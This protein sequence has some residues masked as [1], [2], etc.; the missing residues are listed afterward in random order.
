MTYSNTQQVYGSGHII[1]FLN[2]PFNSFSASSSGSIATI[3]SPASVSI[4][5]FGEG[6]QLATGTVRTFDGLTNFSSTATVTLSSGSDARRSVYGFEVSSG[7]YNASSSVTTSLSTPINDFG[8][9]FA[10]ATFAPTKFNEP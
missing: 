6:L 5:K 2:K 9:T 8:E 4:T 10:A 1:L 7:S 3:S